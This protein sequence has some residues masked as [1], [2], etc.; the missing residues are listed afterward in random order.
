MAP[1]STREEILV[2][3]FA[4]ITG[5]TGLYEKLGDEKAHAQVSDC[6]KLLIDKTIAGGGVHV[7]T[8]GDEILSTFPDADSAISVAIGMQEAL[9]GNPLSIK[10]GCH[11]GHVIH[12]AGDIYGDAVNLAARVV[13]VATRDEIVTTQPTVDELSPQYRDKAR[14][15]D[16]ITVKGKDE[17]TIMYQILWRVSDDVTVMGTDPTLRKSRSRHSLNF[18]YRGKSYSLT[19]ET[20]QFTIG[21]SSKNDLVITDDRA[22]RIHA[23][24]QF[25]RGRFKLVDQSSNG[26]YIVQ[27]NDLSNRIFLK[28][29]LVDLS[30]SGMIGFG[31]IPDAES[32]E[33]VRYECIYK[34]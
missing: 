5:S 32:G 16:T 9:A 18:S 14:H 25:K 23:V 30:G 13:S 24:V 17:P 34:S 27:D 29:E 4:D 12:D 7:K 31:T 22:S 33:A 10:I 26:T 11:L 2:V 6:L 15:L 28:R 8:I 3:L 1:L 21:R 20:N 19:A